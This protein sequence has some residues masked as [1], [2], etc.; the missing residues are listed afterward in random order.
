MGGSGTAPYTQPLVNQLPSLQ[1]PG[2]PFAYDPLWRFYTVNPNNNYAN[3]ILDANG[4]PT[5]P[6]GYYLS[7][8]AG[9]AYEGPLRLPGSRRCPKPTTTA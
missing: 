9:V 8:P 1:G 5:Q 7:D 6:G 2:L 3:G 4:N